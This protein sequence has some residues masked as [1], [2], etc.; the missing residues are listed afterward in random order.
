MARLKMIVV[1]KGRFRG[2]VRKL[3]TLGSGAVVGKSRVDLNSKDERGIPAQEVEESRRLIIQF[4]DSHYLRPLAR[5]RPSRSFEFLSGFSLLLT[6]SFYKS[7]WI[8]WMVSSIIRRADGPGNGTF[9][10]RIFRK[11]HWNRRYVKCFTNTILTVDLNNFQSQPFVTIYL[12]Y[13]RKGNK[14]PIKYPKYIKTS[15]H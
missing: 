7:W 5:S 9:D 6:F 11:F 13:R 1:S 10:R 8:L 12:R 4:Q 14:Y 15:Y 2:L 3:E